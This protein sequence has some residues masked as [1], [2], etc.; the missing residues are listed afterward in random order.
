MRLRIETFPDG[1]LV[2]TNG[3]QEFDLVFTEGATVPQDPMY[4]QQ[5]A[6]LKRIIEAIE[7]V[8]DGGV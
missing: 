8:E 3:D 4:A 2:L 7:R 1:G 5:R 6:Y